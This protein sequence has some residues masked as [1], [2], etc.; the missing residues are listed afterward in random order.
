MNKDS[1]Y[2]ED[3]EISKSVSEVEKIYLKYRDGFE[4]YLKFQ[5]KV[6]RKPTVSISDSTTE[7]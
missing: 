6:Q 1:I 3:N 5:K 7:K 4:T 2:S